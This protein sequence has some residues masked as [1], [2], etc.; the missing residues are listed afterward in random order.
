MERLRGPFSSQAW[1]YVEGQSASRVRWRPSYACRNHSA[2]RRGGRARDTDAQPT[3]GRISRRSPHAPGN[4]SPQ[5]SIRLVRGAVLDRCMLAL[6]SD[7]R[8]L[9]G[10]WILFGRCSRRLLLGRTPRYPRGYPAG[11]SPRP[12]RL[13]HKSPHSART[14]AALAYRAVSIVSNVN[15]VRGSAQ[16]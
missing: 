10:P 3:L 6:R 9:I 11:P 14:C 4:Q 15:P 5:R 2:V 13:A 7:L 1:L 8:F 12:D 16:R